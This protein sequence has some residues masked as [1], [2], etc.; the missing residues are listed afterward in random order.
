MSGKKR[1]LGRGLDVLLAGAKLESAPERMKQVAVERLSPGSFQPRKDI[2]PGKLQELA[3]SISAQGVVQPVVV[4]EV[5]GSGQ[6]EIIAG[7][8]RWR[9]AQL[10]GLKEVPV[11]VRKVSDQAALAIAL[12]ENIQRENLNAME[13][14]EAMKRLLDEYRMTHQQL[15]DALGKSRAAV[16]NL[17]RLN[18]LEDD[19]KPL[20]MSGALEMGHARALLGLNGVMQVSAA[21]RI[22]DRQLTVRAAEALVQ[23]LKSLT[24]EPSSTVP[25]VP[26]SRDPDIRR[27]EDDV[28]AR[29]GA[30]VSIRHGAKGAGQIIIRYGSLDELDGV[31]DRFGHG[32]D[33]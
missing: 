12:I 27:L 6:F 30:S 5:V 32:S 7:E 20:L 17:L 10:A 14:A 22:I 33:H 25:T 11:I 13:E 29:L 4:R 3:D 31:L 2:D 8:R 15:A 1:G 28:S 21:R 23:D 16:S 19:V 18:D 24:D 26:S 9:A